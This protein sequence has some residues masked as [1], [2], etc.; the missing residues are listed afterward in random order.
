M[1]VL[2]GWSSLEDIREAFA[3]YKQPSPV[4]PD[5]EVLFASYEGGG[6]DGDAVV[7]F[8]QEGKL[9]E[10]HG[11]HCSCHGLENQWSPEESTVESLEKTIPSR[12]ERHNSDAVA[13]FGSVL[14][15]LR[16]AQGKT[17]AQD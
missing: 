13:A 10:V 4:P 5:I 17:A 3:D 12:L 1:N 9:Y 15:R 11:G 8:R 16:A 6:Y 2:F 7:V 14:E